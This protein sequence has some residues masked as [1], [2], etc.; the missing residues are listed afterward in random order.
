MTEN[1]HWKWTECTANRLVL[2]HRKLWHT[3]THAHTHCSTDICVP[4]KKKQ[5]VL[6]SNDICNMS[7]SSITSV[8][9]IQL[10]RCLYSMQ[11]NFYFGKVF[12]CKRRLKMRQTLPLTER[13]SL[14]GASH[15]VCVHRNM[16]ADASYQLLRVDT[17][18]EWLFTYFRFH[19]ALSFP[20]TSLEKGNH[21]EY[22]TNPSQ[23]HPGLRLLFCTCFAMIEC[24]STMSV[25]SPMCIQFTKM[26]GTSC[27]RKV[28][29]GCNNFIRLC[30]NYWGQN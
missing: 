4:V 24:S 15:A 19:P 22:D 27:S 8:Q 1:T 23:C 14:T 7:S 21:A 2:Q 3:H 20:R 26:P 28:F 16:L 17:P 10:N 12:L 25:S 29:W 13:N 11:M 5:T 6:Y 9:I 30:P 18:L